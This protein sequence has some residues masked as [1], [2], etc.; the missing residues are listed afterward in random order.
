MTPFT[1]EAAVHATS[2]SVCVHTCVQRHREVLRESL[3]DEN[4]MGRDK[5]KADSTVTL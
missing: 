2:R 1:T 3:E 5:T 4:A